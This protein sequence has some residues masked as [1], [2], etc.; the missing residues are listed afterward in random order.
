MMGARRGGTR[1]GLRAALASVAA[2]G[3]LVSAYLTWAHLSGMVPV[4]AGG[5][6]ACE[7]VQTSRYSEMFGVPV[8]AL[9]LLAYAGL[10]LSAASVGARAALFGLFVALVGALFSA[11]LTYL[12]LFVIR[13]ICHWCVASAVLMAASLLLTAIRASGEVK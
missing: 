6:G 8:A 11:Y 7:T 4:C 1:A 5:S 9:G 13:A 2:A 10:L 12:E 3:L